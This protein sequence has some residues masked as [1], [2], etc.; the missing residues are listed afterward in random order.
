[1]TPH[2]SASFRRGAHLSRRAFTLLEILVVLAII[3]LI[4]TLAITNLTGAFDGAKKD[5]AEMFVKQV[6]QLPLQQYS[7]HIGSY[8]STADGLQALLTPPANK[9]ER[10]RGPYV[11]ESSGIPLD[12]WKQPYQYRFPGI[13]NKNNYD[14]WS[15]GPDETD[16]T[17]DD[18][19]N[20]ATTSE[21]K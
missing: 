4:A 5:T 2:L 16:G 12:P 1:M 6:L 7:I 19:G 8:P 15:K 18:I 13:K 11:K 3:G 14:L 9:A 21:V 17:P 20:W 10:W